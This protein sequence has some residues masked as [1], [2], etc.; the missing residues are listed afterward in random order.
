MFVCNLHLM[1]LELI[2]AEVL[3]KVQAL[4]LQW[5]PEQFHFNS[6]QKNK[7]YKN[8]QAWTTPYL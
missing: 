6:P 5:Q 7:L 4:F 3:T 8:Q 1:L 2:Q